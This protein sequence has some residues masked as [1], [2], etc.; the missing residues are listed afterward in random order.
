MQ[1]LNSR[2]KKARIRKEK[3]DRFWLKFRS[4][5][6]VRFIRKQYKRTGSTEIYIDLYKFNEELLIKVLN[7]LKSEHQLNFN[8]VEDYYVI[9][10]KEPTQINKFNKVQPAEIIIETKPEPAENTEPPATKPVEQTTEQQKQ[11]NSDKKQSE[12]YKPF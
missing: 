8:K 11:Q 10:L 4:R 12:E 7:L 1:I 2:L 6:I 9:N 5:R 3:R